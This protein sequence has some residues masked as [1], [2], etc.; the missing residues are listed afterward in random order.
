MPL[1][2]QSGQQQ[3]FSANVGEPQQHKPR[4]VYVTTNKHNP[5]A[6]IEATFVATDENGNEKT[7]IVK[8]IDAAE[9]FYQ[10]S[11]GQNWLQQQKDRN[12]TRM[13]RSA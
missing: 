6:L 9:L 2:G 8:D 13:R 3:S 4:L 1:Q 7:I 11:E 5:D 10:T 12:V